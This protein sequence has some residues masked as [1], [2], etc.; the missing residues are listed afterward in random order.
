MSSVL[1][2]LTASD[3]I[4]FYQNFLPGNVFGTTCPRNFTWRVTFHPAVQHSYLL[5][6]FL[7]QSCFATSLGS[8]QID[9]CIKMSTGIMQITTTSRSRFRICLHHSVHPE[10]DGEQQMRNK[11][12]SRK[13]TK[14]LVPFNEDGWFHLPMSESKVKFIFSF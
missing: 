6:F 12:V 14:I 1:E 10:S 7:V 4:R 5:F 9:M 3:D 8:F 11:H 2:E 13:L